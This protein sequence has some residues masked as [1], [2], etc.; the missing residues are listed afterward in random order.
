MCDCA[1][2][3]QGLDRG[4][5]LS[6][7]S[8]VRGGGVCGRVAATALA[9][10]R[11][12]GVYLFVTPFPFHAVVFCR[13]AQSSHY[14]VRCCCTAWQGSNNESN[15][16]TAKSLPARQPL[17]WGPRKGKSL[18]V[19]A[20]PINTSLRPWYIESATLKM[21]N[22]WLYS[23]EYIFFLGGEWIWHAH[24]CLPVLPVEW[25]LKGDPEDHFTK[26]L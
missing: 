24:G 3:P 16:W 26:G 25:S 11:A 17:S 9:C 20:V 12:S 15:V 6:S 2:A 19:I 18:W 21:G 8:A 4:R 5:V 10:S 23:P 13:A 7:Q 22:Q 14:S 1:L